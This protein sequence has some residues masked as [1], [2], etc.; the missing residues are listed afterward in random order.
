MIEKWEYREEYIPLS[1]RHERLNE[2]GESGWELVQ[3][4]D[5]GYALFKRGRQEHD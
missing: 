4:G 2:L 1:I 5:D 3:Y